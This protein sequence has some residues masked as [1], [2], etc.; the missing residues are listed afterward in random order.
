MTHPGDPYRDVDA[1]PDPREFVARLEERGETPTQSRLR[2]RFLRFARVGAGASVLEVGSGSG[3]VARDLVRMVGAGGRVTGV[4]PSRTFVIAARRLA[5]QR[6]LAGRIDFRVADGR[7]LPFKSG[8]FDNTIA[9]TVFLHVDRPEEILAE[10]VRVTRRTGVVAVQD[11]D[12]GTIV[13]AHPDRRLTARILEA[14]AERIYVEPLSGRRLPGLLV[15]AGL[16][17]IR[18]VTDVYQDTTLEPYTQTFLLRRA[19][20]AVKLGV[21]S[22][23]AAQTWLDGFTHLARIGGFLMT[24]NFY[25]AAGVRP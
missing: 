15:A 14:V 18:L 21:V 22:A 5:R 19:E 4:D 23:S 10:M 1:Q 9:V 13:L 25:G 2:R 16:Q 17:R 20:H 24:M 3:V 7:R 8:R 11:Q 12:I 6:G